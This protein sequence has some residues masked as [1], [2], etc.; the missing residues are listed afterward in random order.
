MK[1]N[2]YKWK[3]IINNT[4]GGTRITIYACKRSDLKSKSFKF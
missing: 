3:Q 4:E 1:E 2:G